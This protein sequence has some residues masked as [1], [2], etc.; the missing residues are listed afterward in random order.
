MSIEDQ[1]ISLVKK[2]DAATQEFDM[3]VTFHEVWKPTLYDENLRTRM[4]VSY[5]T[6]A[7]HVIRMA[8]RREMLLALMR[9]WDNNRKNVGMHHIANILRA[10]SVISALAKKRAAPYRDAHVENQMKQE[11]LQLRDE[12]VALIGKY[13]KDGADRPVLKKLRTVRNKHLAHR[14]IQALAATGSEKFDKEIE[15]FYQ[16]MSKLIS[17]LCSLVKGLGYDPQ[18][19]AEVYCTYA[20]LFWAGARGE[21]TEGHPNYR[22]I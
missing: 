16:D 21:R 2:V 17:L 6:N 8:L 9:L 5:A 7:F 22:V 14:P 10:S 12:I 13:F 19:T 4:G 1:I 18:E 20:T 15:T 11:L 3:A